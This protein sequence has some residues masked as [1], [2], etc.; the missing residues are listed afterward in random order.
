MA[1]VNQAATTLTEEEM[2]KDSLMS[3]K[4]MTDS[5]NI[6]TGECA[7][8][9][10]RG[11][12]LNILEDEHRIQADIFCCLQTNGWYQTEPADMQKIEQTKQKYSVQP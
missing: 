1:N 9:Q 2:L 8:E 3:Q 4:Q 7:N 10:L 6:F 12:F 5:Y 11:A